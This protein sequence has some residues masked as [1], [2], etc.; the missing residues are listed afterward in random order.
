A[1]C[2]CLLSEC[3][4]SEWSPW[5]RC[6]GS[7]F[8]ALTVRNR[9]VIRPALPDK[10]NAPVKR[11]PYLYETRFCAIPSCQENSSSDAIDLPSRSGQ[12]RSPVRV[13]VEKKLLRK[14]QLETAAVMP[15]VEPVRSKTYVSDEMLFQKQRDKQ[16]E[17]G[18][19]RRNYNGQL[20][21]TIEA[22]QQQLEQEHAPSQSFKEDTYTEHGPR[23]LRSRVD[24]EKTKSS[25]F[26]GILP[27]YLK[28]A[29]ERIQLRGNRMDET[30]TTTDATT[31][32]VLR[33][34][35]SAA[36]YKIPV[37]DVRIRRVLHRNK[38]LIKA[39]IEAYKLRFTTTTS[40]FVSTTVEPAASTTMVP[41]NELF[42]ELAASTIDSDIEADEPKA[43]KPFSSAKG[44]SVSRT[45][46]SS[47][48]SASSASETKEFLDQVSN[49]EYHSTTTKVSN[50]PETATDSHL[51][52]STSQPPLST[53]A[54]YTEDSVTATESTTFAQ[55]ST[56]SVTDV[57]QGMVENATSSEEL[58]D[59]SGTKHTAGI[60]NQSLVAFIS[61]S[62]GTENTTTTSTST[63]T[64]VENFAKSTVT[65]TTQLPFWPKKGYVPNTRKH[66]S[67]ITSKLYMTREIIQALSDEPIRR[68]P[69]LKLDCLENR[70][71]CKV[72][73]TE[74]ADGSPPMFTK[75]YYRP[76]GSDTCIAYHYPR[77]SPREEMEE[78]P[79]Q[80][81]QNCQDL[82]FA[83]PEKRI[84]PLLE[85]SIE[86]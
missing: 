4:L 14:G 5:S 13:V 38:K 79:I 36:D 81:E 47:N 7:C 67:E 10:P 86:K 43:R 34:L 51:I 3:E 16:S 50:T 66:A 70:R 52:G 19:R 24:E 25:K 62:T 80:Y 11:C 40:A 84:D 46:G 2:E 23:P 59:V 64:S 42:M 1:E 60:W 83:G 78:Q 20:T 41:T 75:R 33:E 68:S 12:Q 61:S 49:L 18:H 35:E 71:C 56:K 6:Y 32:E 22:L 65:T 77:C 53:A 39:L 48:D 72:T 30:Q 26:A 76:R 15:A 73:R 17:S 31:A 9:D 82:C 58:Q 44:V 85:L 8:Y 57:E 74:C 21:R 69:I 27:K 28:M 55:A 54:N 29:K 63:S 45:E 37:D